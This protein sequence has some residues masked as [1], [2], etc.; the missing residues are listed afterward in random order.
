MIDFVNTEFDTV[1]NLVTF[2]I[3]KSYSKVFYTTHR[4]INH[5]YLQIIKYKTP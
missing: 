5:V 4:K 1:D 3:S 2:P